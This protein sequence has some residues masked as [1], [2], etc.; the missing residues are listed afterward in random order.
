VPHPNDIEERGDRLETG[1]FNKVA[2]RMVKQGWVKVNPRT[3]QNLWQKY[4][5]SILYPEVYVHDV[6]R[7]KGSGE[8]RSITTEELQAMVKEVPFSDRQDLRSLAIKVGI[9]KSTLHRAL[10]YGAL[11]RTTSSIKPHLTPHNM[12]QRVDY[13]RSFIESADN[14]FSDMMDRVDIDEKWFYITKKRSKYIVVPGEEAPIRT[15]K[16]K[17]HLVKVMCLTAVARP[18][19]IGTTGEWWDGKIG[20]WFFVDTV[21]AART[22]KNCPAGTLETKTVKVNR[23][24]T[25]A[26]IVNNLLPAIEA[27]WPPGS[28]KR[29]RIQQDNATPHPPPGSNSLINTMLAEMATHGWDIAFVTQP[30]NSPDTN[31]LDLAFFRAIQ[32]I[33]YQKP[34]KNIDELINNVIIAFQELPLDVCIKVWTTAQ[35]VMNE[36][37]L[38]QGSNNYKLPHAGK[39]KIARELGQSIPYRLPCK[40]ITSNSHLDGTAIKSA[41]KDRGKYFIAPKYYYQSSVY[42]C[43][44]F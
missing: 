1:A 40:A 21:A 5:Q 3:V 30:P 23:D 8:K 36:I 22:S 12:I 20:T 26:M 11:Q 34:S 7:K 17:S 37:I 43:M 35:M 38:A 25:V 10:K 41:M 19:E 14:Y 31:T 29:V 39:D 42:C 9:P 33:Q 27:N 4:K 44:T 13:C 32:S 18:R 24:V 28:P 2:E 16:H 6:S 15:C